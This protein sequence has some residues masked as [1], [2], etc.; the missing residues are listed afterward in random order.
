ARGERLAGELER[1]N[2]DR[3]QVA[4]RAD[5]VG[6]QD[7]RNLA[8]GEERRVALV[9]SELA[10]AEQL[11]GGDRTSAEHNRDEQQRTGADTRGCAPDGGGSGREVVERLGR[12]LVGRDARPLELRGERGRSCNRT[13]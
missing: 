10:A 2:R 12:Q 1:R 3:G 7:E 6:A 9:D 11:D 8:G 5:S 4:R 13:R